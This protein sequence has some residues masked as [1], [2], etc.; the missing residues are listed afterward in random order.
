MHLSL[1]WLQHVSAITLCSNN[2]LLAFWISPDP[3][4]ELHL[5]NPFLTKLE[6]MQMHLYHW[7][8]TEISC[9]PNPIHTPPQ[10]R[11][12]AFK[13][14]TSP[15]DEFSRWWYFLLC[16]RG[17]SLKMQFWLVFVII[18]LFL[19]KY[20][21]QN[22]PAALILGIRH[23]VVTDGYK[24]DETQNPLREFPSHCPRSQW[25]PAVNQ[26]GSFSISELLWFISYANS[27]YQLCKYLFSSHTL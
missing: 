26:R 3:L 24:V 6:F 17:N 16:T 23:R 1:F 22:H 7:T 8:G 2:S 27:W 19:W 15:W 4:I 5:I 11:S 18:C 21:K 12:V 13:G 25:C 14:L 20:G 9:Y 10:E